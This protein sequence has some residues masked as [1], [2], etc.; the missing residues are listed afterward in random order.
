[1]SKL[2]SD[3]VRYYRY[4]VLTLIILLGLSAIF[5]ILLSILL[6]HSNLSWE[7]AETDILSALQ[8][9]IR[10]FLLAV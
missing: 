1:M 4:L 10:L 5:S 2:L 7:H 8:N 9:Q 6:V 3:E